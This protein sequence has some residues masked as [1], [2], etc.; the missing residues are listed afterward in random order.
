MGGQTRAT[1]DAVDAFSDQWSINVSELMVWFQGMQPPA[2][3]L[4][5]L[6]LPLLLLS[7]LLVSLVLLSLQALSL[8]V[9]S[10]LQLSWLM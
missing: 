7:L 10:V 9:L 2:L 4:S 6:L 5:F 3:L 1:M 8:P